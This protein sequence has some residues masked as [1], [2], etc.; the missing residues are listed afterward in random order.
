MNDVDTFKNYATSVWVP[1]YF[2]E[3]VSELDDIHL[4][5]FYYQVKNALEFLTT[6][7]YLIYKFKWIKDKPFT[8]LSKE[9]YLQYLYNSESFTFDIIKTEW[10]KVLEEKYKDDEDV[11]R[12][13]NQCF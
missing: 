9:I 1:G 12:Y 2:S 10:E 11:R 4:N 8:D 5:W 7:A 3:Y 6:E 13:Y